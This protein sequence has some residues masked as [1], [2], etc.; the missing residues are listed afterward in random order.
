MF[1]LV[2]HFWS[3]R[4]PISFLLDVLRFCLSSKNLTELPGSVKESNS[5][6]KKLITKF[7]TDIKQYDKTKLEVQVLFP[8]TSPVCIVFCFI[9]FCMMVTFISCYMADHKTFDGWIGFDVFFIVL[10]LIVN[11]YAF[12]IVLL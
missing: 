1:F 10:V 8:F 12:S 5:L 11:I 4:F 9:Y 6:M 2:H 7:A 3:E